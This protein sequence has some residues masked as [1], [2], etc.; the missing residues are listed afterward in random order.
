MS[1]HVSNRLAFNNVSVIGFVMLLLNLPLFIASDV[2]GEVE[3]RLPTS[4]TEGEVVSVT[5]CDTGDDCLDDVRERAWSSPIFVDH[6]A[7]GRRRALA[8]VF[9]ARALDFERR[10]RELDTH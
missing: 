9:D 10:L 1:R 7:R 2:V 8:G 6:G 3:F 4:I 5:I